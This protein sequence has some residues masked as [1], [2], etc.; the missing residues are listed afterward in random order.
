MTE[1]AIPNSLILVL[2]SLVGAPQKYSKGLAQ[3]E[4]ET[5]EKHDK[6]AQTLS[7]LESPYAENVLSQ[8]S[9]YWFFSLPFSSVLP[10]LSWP[11]ARHLFSMRRRIS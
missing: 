1:I 7:S 5:Q 2:A 6:T 4:K 9:H 10:A 3:K 8:S 11:A